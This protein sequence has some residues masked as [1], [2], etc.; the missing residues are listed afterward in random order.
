MF[1]KKI[2][3]AAIAALTLTAGSSFADDTELYV[4]DSGSRTGA[5]PQVLIIF[6]NSGSMRTEETYAKDSYDPTKVYPALS[7]NAPSE[8]TLYFSSDGIPRP[9]ENSNEGRFAEAVNNCHTSQSALQRFGFFTDKFQYLRKR[10]SG[11]FDWKEPSENTKSNRILAMECNEDIQTE[12]WRN[13]SGFPSGFPKEGSKTDSYTQVDDSSPTKDFEAAIEIAKDADFHRA[14]AVTIYTENYLRWYHQKG[15]VSKKQRIE[16]AREVITNTIASTPGVDFGLAVFNHNTNYDVEQGGRIVSGIKQMTEDNKVNLLKTIDGLDP[17]TNTPLCETLYEAKRYFAGEAVVY[18][19]DNDRGLRPARDTSIENGNKYI[20][21]FKE[22]QNLAF[23]VYMTDG[24]PTKDDNADKLVKGLPG[25]DKDAFTWSGK[26]N[27]LPNLAE[28]MYKNDVN[29]NLPDT[30]TIKTFTIGFSDGAADAAPLLQAA[31]NRGGGKYFAAKDASDLQAALQQVF[32]DILEVNASFTS[33]SIASNNF[34]RTQTFDA[35]YYAMFLPNRGPRWSGNLKKFKVTGSGDIVDKKGRIAIADDGNISPKACSY[36]TDDAVCSANNGGDGNDVTIGGA[37]EVLKKAESRK[38]YGNL[39]A[40]GELTELTHIQASIH[41][42]GETELATHMNSTTAELEALF[43]WA[44]GKDIDDED[45]DNSTSDIR[46]DVLGDPLHSKPLAINYGT[47]GNPDIRILMGTNHGFMHMFRDTG[48]TVSESWAFM[49]YELLPNLAE[50]RNNEP[51]GVHS[52]YGLDS[53]PVG[54][55]KTSKTGVERAWVF[56]GMR[57]GGKS[58]Y[59]LDVTTPDNPK[60]MWTISA[61]SPGME[62]LA[63]TWA[64]PVVTYIP[65]W[66]RGN[67]DPDQAK[68]VVIVGAGYSPA[69]KDSAAVGIPDSEG[70]GVF[71]LDAETGELVHRFTP[72]SGS[73]TTVMSGITD[74]IPNSVAVLDSNSDGLT[75]RIYATDTGANVWRMDL[76]GATPSSNDAPWS[77]FK[78]AALGGNVQI[79]DRRFFAEPVV[80]QTMFSN[81]TEHQIVSES[82]GG[83]TTQL[84]YQNVPYDAVVIGTGHRPHPTDKTRKDMF[85]T[86]QDRNVVT[87][88]FGTAKNP[89][90][91]PLVLDNLYR[92]SEAPPTTEAEL[93]RFGTKRGWYYSF[94]SEGEKNLAAASIIFGRVYFT[95][96]VPGDTSSSNTCLVAGQ[97]RLYSFD[98]HRGTRTYSQEYLDV[99]ERV[100]D[101]PQLV[102]P[103]SGDGD[104]Y[105]YLIGIGNAGAQME[106]QAPAK[107]CAEGDHRCVGGGMRTNRIYYYAQ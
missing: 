95:S 2:T 17:E 51:T 78:F 91:E 84:S 46:S 77:A 103:P 82:T 16:I 94:G 8:S 12:N 60:L 86:L 76:P 61:D 14:D 79:A 68:P 21:P 88:S 9:D 99:G 55:V 66:P 27:Y 42:G 107:G 102:I 15:N 7:D 34:D 83:I 33:P 37:V 47:Q 59:A 3:A 71:I 98:L 70:R 23:V 87:K 85:F 41:A 1:I 72:T 50:L 92:V 24:A 69:T 32:T 73:N 106:V 101:T 39:G 6:D 90:P 4:Y 75:D 89:I 25:V 53:P 40:N 30:Q 104:D 105:M 45:G 31:A 67:K 29:P 48:N 97:G 44:H 100:P 35:V 62:E 93:V 43:K 63:Q 26:S 56:F 11:K 58:Y 20:S 36:W 65:G 80:A 57:R 38:L 64:E 96:Y 49:P 22:C 52:V 13:N 81:V 74:S 54:Y 5:R 19:K 18:G 10:N 28:W